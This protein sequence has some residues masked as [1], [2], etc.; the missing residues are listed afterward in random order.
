MTKKRKTYSAEFKEN[1]VK[2]AAEVGTQ[3]AAS[4]LGVCKASIGIWKRNLSF[5]GE[6]SS[7]EI[8]WEKEALKLQKE[9]SYLRKINDVLKKSTAIFSQNDLPGSK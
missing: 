5:T 7:S 4:Q 2:L 1:A 6:T 8:D 3:E 9:N